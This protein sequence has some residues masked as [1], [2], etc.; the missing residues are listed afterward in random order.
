MPT[1]QSS[2]S[3]TLNISIYEEKFLVKFGYSVKIF[4][5]LKKIKGS[6]F[7]KEKKGWILP[8]ESFKDLR[9]SKTLGSLNFNLEFDADEFERLAKKSMQAK[10]SALAKYKANCYSLSIS[11]IKL[12]E[13]DTYVAYK[14]NQLVFVINNS[15]NI[16]KS[17]KQL[18][19]LQ[20][21]RLNNEYHF[22]VL[23]IKPLIKF[24]KEKRLS[25]AVEDKAAF[26][27]KQAKDFNDS[28]VEIE[29]YI[30]KS[31]SNRVL[32]SLYFPFISKAKEDDSFTIECPS[33]ELLK[34]I[35]KTAGKKVKKSSNLISASYKQ[36][37]EVLWNAR[38]HSI[39]IFVDEEVYKVLK[40]YKEEYKEG[41]ENGYLQS[42]L[43][44]Q[45]PSS[46]WFI[47]E[48]QLFFATLLNT[49]I[50]ADSELIFSHAFSEYRIYKVSEFEVKEVFLK[51]QQEYNFLVSKEVSK[52]IK[53]I[54]EKEKKL[55]RQKELTTLKDAKLN[56]V[57]SELAKELYPHQRVA[58]SWILENEFG[59]LGDDMGLGKTL[60][61]LTAF[62]EA[63]YLQQADFLLVICPQSLVRNWKSETDYWFS[64]LKTMTLSKTK[65]KRQ[66]D[67][68]KLSEYRLKYDCLVLNFEIV[69]VE[70]VFSGIMNLCKKR[71]VFLCIDESQRAK[72]P[73][74]KTFQ[75]LKQIAKF[76]KKRFLLS[77][78]PMPKDISDIWSQTYLLDQGER[79]GQS[80]YKWL[81]GIGELGTKYS[82]Y[83]VKR[84]YPEEV[85]KSIKRVQELLLRRKKEQVV[86][87][88]SKIFSSRTVELKGDQLKRY[89]M[90]RKELLVRISQTDGTTF[91]KEIN[92]ILEEYLRAV[93][94][95]SNP[96]LVDE[97]Y[98][99]EPAK[100]KELDRL[101]DE[102]VK[103]K[104]EKLVIWT[105]YRGNTDE[106]CVRYKEF[107]VAS[108]T[109]GIS[110][111]DRADI[112]NEFQDRESKLKILVAIPAAGGV[113]ITLTAASTAI[114][115]DKT[116]NAEHWMQSIDRIHRIGQDRIVNIISLYGCG[117][118][119]L[120][121]K[122]LRKKTE[123]Q[124]K[125]LGDSPSEEA[126]ET[127]DFFPSKD[128]LIEALNN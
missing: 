74:S 65:A 54:D 45:R 69:R 108:F 98:D 28:L 48:E 123:N 104:D 63:K 68:L 33:Y 55:I 94:I 84:F 23:R 87:L 1:K 34:F 27:L 127:K 111:K 7:N 25:F 20:D 101:V 124:S 114:Y 39:D 113:G 109:G 35:A 52:F 88:P 128:E 79:F 102:I 119:H 66:R 41:M 43:V 12:C 97:S 80:Y 57:N 62:E 116:W 24:L 125:L 117:V 72:N 53:K 89:D 3:G 21:T 105:N 26:Y 75:A 112:V 64:R 86:N 76:T 11:N 120:I 10:E 59:L 9:E 110:P 106:L 115:L 60:S 13:L 83:A 71:E 91:E 77:G 100:F 14:N 5:E 46:F 2:S 42:N 92:N 38:V 107:G 16:R 19:F 126:L 121:A 18:P 51:V 47:F 31:S 22:S 15:I 95:A 49:T 67:L 103:E 99:G 82:Q 61:I 73:A 8:I 81:S 36:L 30:Y 6:R 58:V 44:L 4:N 70:D 90:A 29:R 56:I 50:I 96:R 78:T 93:Q 32:D 118:D 40:Q 85:D 37:E 17:L 122:N